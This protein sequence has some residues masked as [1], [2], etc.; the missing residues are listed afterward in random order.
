ME[1]RLAP[2]QHYDLAVAALQRGAEHPGPPQAIQ[3]EAL[4]GIGHALCGILRH[5]MTS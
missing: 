5:L 1:Y 2:A 3:A 4:I